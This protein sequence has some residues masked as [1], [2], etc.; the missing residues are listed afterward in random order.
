MTL[1]TI[2]TKCAL[3]FAAAA[4]SCSA[5]IAFAQSNAVVEVAQSNANWRHNM[6]LFC[7][8]AFDPKVCIKVGK[9]FESGKGGKKNVKRAIDM[10]RVACL[11]QADGCAL[12][13]ALIYK[14]AKT[15]KGRTAALKPW[16][17]GCR[18]KSGRA[19][20]GVGA[21]YKSG[22][23]GKVDLVKAFIFFDK[24][25]SFASSKG[26]FNLGYAYEHG[27]GVEQ[28]LAKSTEKYGVACEGGSSMGCLSAGLAYLNGTGVKKSFTTSTTFFE[29]GC[30]LGDLESCRN[31][32][33][34]CK[35]MLEAKAASENGECS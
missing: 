9:A 8:E 13:G 16:L 10:F 20:N 23:L 5:P 33:K 32:G 29:K 4:F 19:C 22:D 30:A 28:N 1:S 3:L 25:C 14:T 7:R 24:A 21:L 18:I 2:R 17:R 15:P 12:Q 35:K 26:C 31:I 34:D 11:R 6:Y 27:S